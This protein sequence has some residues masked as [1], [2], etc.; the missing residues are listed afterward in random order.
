M[1]ALNFLLSKNKKEFIHIINQLKI[2]KLAS[3]KKKY[4]K[5]EKKKT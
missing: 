4:V 1:A 5:V 3:L 2:N